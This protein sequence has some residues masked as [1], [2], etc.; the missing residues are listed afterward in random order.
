MV[1]LIVVLVVLLAMILLFWLV[2]FLLLRALVDR[3]SGR[4]GTVERALAVRVR[5]ELD[6]LKTLSPMELE[7]HPDHDRARV[8]TIAGRRAT[9]SWDTS[10]D[11]EEGT[12]EVVL[13]VDLKVFN[14][15]FSPSTS[16]CYGF[17]I[18]REGKRVD[19][20]PEELAQHD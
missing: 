8:T 12:L 16:Q 10:M 1:F 14:T 2:P 11:V 4:R 3:L 5:E 19:L 20:Q 7:A 18:T 15:S 9:F 13:D 17:K 6:V